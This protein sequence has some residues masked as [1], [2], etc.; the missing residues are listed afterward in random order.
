MMNL[1]LAGFSLEVIYIVLHH[2]DMLALVN[3]NAGLYSLSNTTPS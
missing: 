1:P 2:G 3:R